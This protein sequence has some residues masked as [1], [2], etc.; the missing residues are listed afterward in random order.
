MRSSVHSSATRA[1][2]VLDEATA[3][4]YIGTDKMIQRVVMGL[5]CAVVIIAHRLDTVVGC[6]RVV[7]LERGKILQIGAPNDVLRTSLRSDESWGRK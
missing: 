1:S 4:V 7:V 5:D 3:S 2:L 6:D